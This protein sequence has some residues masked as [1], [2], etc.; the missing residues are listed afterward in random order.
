MK[1]SIIITTFNR[2]I[3]LKRA[4]ESCVNQVTNYDYEIE[5]NDA[6]RHILIIDPGSINR[7]VEAFRKAQ[8]GTTK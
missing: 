8:E 4:I 5:L 6:K 7:F 1:A 2:P 3:F